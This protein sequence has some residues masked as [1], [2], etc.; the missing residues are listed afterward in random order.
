MPITTGPKPATQPVVK[1]TSDPIAEGAAMKEIVD[2][3]MTLPEHRRGPVFK[4]ACILLG[5]Y[6]G[7]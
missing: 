4:A 3:L 7:D 5:I 2:K 1:P 6:C